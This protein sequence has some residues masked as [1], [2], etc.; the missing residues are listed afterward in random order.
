MIEC[1]HLSLSPSSYT[2]ALF[3]SP[4]TSSPC[5]LPTCDVSPCHPSH[6]CKV[7]VRVWEREEGISHQEDNLLRACPAWTRA[8][9]RADMRAD[10]HGKR[11][12]MQK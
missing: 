6:I 10:T 9:V 3:P 7:E 2:P 12:G 5:P 8:C 11:A 1:S 4:A